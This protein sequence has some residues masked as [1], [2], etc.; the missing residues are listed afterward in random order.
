MLT[1]K[2]AAGIGLLSLALFSPALARAGIVDSQFA[3]EV[4]SETGI[5]SEARTPVETAITLISAFLGLLGVITLV[6]ILYA[7]FL[8]LTAGGNE[9]KIKEAKGLLKGAVLGAAIILFSYTIAQLIFSTI[10]SATGQG[11][12][13]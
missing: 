6:I 11:V 13:N 4:R 10:E 1:R 5:G 8:W 12:I 3:R 7:G 9:E 2:I